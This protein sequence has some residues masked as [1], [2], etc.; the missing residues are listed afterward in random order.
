MNY[1]ECDVTTLLVC[2]GTQAVTVIDKSDMIFNCL[3]KCSFENS[4]RN[5]AKKIK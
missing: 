3:N 1:D 5:P 4:S 2:A